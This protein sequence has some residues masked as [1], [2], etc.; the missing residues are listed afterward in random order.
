MYSEEQFRK[1]CEL[2]EQW[3]EHQIEHKGEG[4][5]SGDFNRSLH[6]WKACWPSSEPCGAFDV[7][8]A[9]VNGYRGHKYGASEIIKRNGLQVKFLQELKFGMD[10]ENGIKKRNK[11]Q[12]H[13]LRTH[14]WSEEYHREMGV[15][16]KIKI[17]PNV[18]NFVKW[19]LRKM[20]IWAEGF[21][22]RC[23]ERVVFLVWWWN[24]GNCP[25]EE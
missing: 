11:V 24:A 1:M 19:A 20:T 22:T 14:F 25:P 15:D 9:Q 23:P 6:S 4:L 13:G 21:D 2:D 16:G 7:C 5:D 8:E 3:F 17:V 12:T 10:V 18:D